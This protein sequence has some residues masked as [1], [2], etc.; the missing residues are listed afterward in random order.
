[1]MLLFVVCCLVL[2]VFDCCLLSIVW[3]SLCVVCCS[4]VDCC[5]LFVVFVLLIVFSQIAR[6]KTTEIP[7][8][9]CVCCLL[10]AV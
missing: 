7:P 2:C 4:F 1:M 6:S 3:C 9:M 10:F 5:L 8:S